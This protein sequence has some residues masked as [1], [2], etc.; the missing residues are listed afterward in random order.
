MN[1]RD[2]P[3]EKT[4]PTTETPASTRREGARTAPEKLSLASDKDTEGQGGKVFG[5]EESTT[6]GQTPE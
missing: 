4:G 3:E 5:I 2:V 6:E 1:K